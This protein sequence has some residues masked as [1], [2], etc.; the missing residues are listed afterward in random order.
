MATS[1]SPAHA[2]GV[3]C[4]SADRDTPWDSVLG[5]GSSEHKETTGRSQGWLPAPCEVE[6]APLQ[7]R[8][9]VFL[10]RWALLRCTLLLVGVVP[11]LCRDPAFCSTWPWCSEQP[12]VP[13]PWRSQ[14]LQG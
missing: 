13:Q 14:P 5:L 9:L 8:S 11:V 12:D 6:G 7:R 2:A 10:L 4:H 1:C 3:E